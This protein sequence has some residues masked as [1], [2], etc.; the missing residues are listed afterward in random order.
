MTRCNLNRRAIQTQFKQIMLIKTKKTQ[1]EKKNR[2]KYS[3][4]Q[5]K[6]KKKEITK[7]RKWCKYTHWN[8]ATNQSTQMH[9]ICMSMWENVLMFVYIY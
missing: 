6:Q 4:G 3:N 5:A 8:F 2:R 7:I 9:L 1:N